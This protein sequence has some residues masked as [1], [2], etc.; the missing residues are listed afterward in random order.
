MVKSRN[1]RVPA[2]RAATPR[3]TKAARPLPTKTA[4]SRR[5][6]P[7]AT[8]TA[9]KPSG[10]PGQTAGPGS[11]SGSQP[12]TQSHGNRAT[13]KGIGQRRIDRRA[14]TATSRTSRQPSGGAATAPSETAA[15]RV[16]VREAET[17]RSRAGRATAR[18][19]RAGRRGESRL[20]PQSDRTHD[21]AAARSIRQRAGRSGT[22][23]SVA[24][25]PA[26]HGTLGQ[27]LGRDVPPLRTA[28]KEGQAARIEL[29]ATLRSLGLRPHGA[30]L[31]ATDMT[32]PLTE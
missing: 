22:A 21:P 6:S 1:K 9:K 28:G 16:P 23:R 14:A 2:D 24:M 4:K 26:G 17:P 19:R 20:H 13:T 3:P 27:P 18:R 10:Q 32:T 25:E 8:A 12:G 29:D 7:A 5:T 11:K 15:R 30:R 31:P